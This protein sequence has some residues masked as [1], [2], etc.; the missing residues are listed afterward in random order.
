MLSQF[1]QQ[2]LN[3][4]IDIRYRFDQ[5]IGT[6]EDRGHRGYRIN[7]WLFGVKDVSSFGYID[8]QPYIVINEVEY[9]E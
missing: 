5:T 7:N 2:N 1:I 6:L 8:G 4:T 9:A 3:K